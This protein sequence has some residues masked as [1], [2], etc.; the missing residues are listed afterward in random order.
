VSA[1]PVDTSPWYYRYRVYT[2]ASTYFFGFFFG[3]TIAGFMGNLTPGFATLGYA[4]HL[5]SRGGLGLAL[6]LTILGAAARL[7]GSS[8]L[9]A[10]VVY[11]PDAR[12]STLHVDGPYRFTRNPLYLGN[13]FIAAGIGLLGPLPVTLLVT[14]G[15]LLI[16]F[17]LIRTEE[18]F[19]I[20]VYG[21]PYRR[22]L[23]SVPTLVP[24]F[25][26]SLPA[27]RPARENASLEQGLRAELPFLGLTLAMLICYLTGRPNGALFW[28]TFI[29]GMGLRSVMGR[30]ERNNIDA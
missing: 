4:L 26:Q 18:R 3:Y 16:V 7:W 29:L 5:G 17:L 2:I 24:T 20:G 27:T 28:G 8:Y 12:A 23:C 14:L 1:T 6:L 15:N 25:M 10:A 13:I 9:T 22:Y 19:L 11:N 30:S 21:E